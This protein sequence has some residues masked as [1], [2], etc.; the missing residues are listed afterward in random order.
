MVPES[1]SG[2]LISGVN[3]V[4]AGVSSFW[5]HFTQNLDVAGFAAW[6]L[7][8][9]LVLVLPVVVPVTV[10]AGV[11]SFSPQSIQNLAVVGLVV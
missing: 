5:P 3:P 10:S 11:S 8:H 7:G 2:P 4:S 6:Q 9:S 1:D